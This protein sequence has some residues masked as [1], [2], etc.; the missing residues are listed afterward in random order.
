MAGKTERI[1][2]Y[3]PGPYRALPRPNALYTLADAFGNEL[4]R[5]ENGLAALMF[6]HW[7]DKAD[8]GADEIADL[9]CIAALYG[10]AP[11]DA[12][13]L[14]RPA[15][16]TCPQ[17]ASSETIEAFRL[18]LKRYIRTY[19]D[20]TP[21]VLGVL[22]VVAE[23][24]G[25]ELAD[26][27]ARLDTW[28]TR[29]DDRATVVL[30]ANDDAGSALLGHRA[31]EASGSPARAASFVGTI[32]LRAGFALAPNAS[33]RLGVDGGAF[34]TVDL[35]AFANDV[36]DDRTAAIARALELAI[37]ALSAH[38]ASGRLA[39]ASRSFGTASRLA[40]DDVDGDSA[41]A[42]LG[43]AAHRYRG[44]DATRATLSGRIAL[45]GGIA[46][47]GPGEPRYLRLLIDGTLRG[48]V[49]CAAGIPGLRSASEIAQAIDAQFGFALAS[50]TDDTLTLASQTGG[51]G[52]RIAFERATSDDAREALFGSVSG[53]VFGSDAEAASVTGA[54]DLRGGIDLHERSQLRVA[55]DGKLPVTIDC[56]GVSP[57]ETLPNEIVEAIN[58]ALGAQ[59]ATQDGARVTLR[60]RTIGSTSS[61]AFLAAGATDARAA[62]FGIPER[63]AMGA[64]AS[65]AEIVGTIDLSKDVDIGGTRFLDLAFDGG[66]PIAIDLRA[67]VPYAPATQS[68]LA[69]ASA[70]ARAIDDAVGAAV[71]TLRGNRLVIASRETGAFSAVTLRS[72]ATTVTRRFVTRGLL[73][74]DAAPV[75][76]GTTHALARGRAPSA[77]R[78]SGTVDLRLG[79]D[80]SG[81]RAL[82][83][84]VDGRAPIEIDCASAAGARARAL[85]LDELLVALRAALGDV[86]IVASD[87]GRVVLT[88]KTGG[89]AS[90]I[91]FLAGGS[92]LASLLG[93]S[94]GSA[95]GNDA[96]GV[97]FVATAD[98][99]G[100]VDLTTA[101]H[102][103]LAIDGKIAEID[104]AA[105][106]PDPAHVGLPALVARI[107]LAFGTTV[108]TSDERVLSLRSGTTGAASTIEVLAPAATDA[109]RAL[110]G[111]A[112]GRTYRGRDAE[113]AHVHGSVALAATN[114]LR[115]R[116]FLR[117]A[118]NGGAWHDIDCAGADPAATTPVEIAR[119][120][121]LAI[122]ALA[123]VDGAHLVL[124]APLPGAAS[125]L[126][127]AES[128]AGDARARV[129]GDVPDVTNGEAASSATIAGAVDLLA[130][131][132]LSGGSTLALALDGAPPITIDVAGAAPERTA[133]AEIVGA[134]EA[135]LP[136]VARASADDRLLLA[137][138]RV[139]ALARLELVPVRAIDLVDY[140][141]RATEATTTLA[142]GDRW[143]V[144]NDGA[145]AAS[146]TL[147]ICASQGVDGVQLVRLA[148]GLRLRIKALVGS[149]GRVRVRATERGGL[150][151]ESIAANG[152]TTMLPARALASGPIGVH[153]FVPSTNAVALRAIDAATPRTRALTLDDPENPHVA[154]LRA[155]DD[156]ASDIELRAH[157]VEADLTTIAGTI[158]TDDDGMATIRGRL[159]F[160]G[161][162]Y[163]LHDASET[164][165][166][167]V[168]QTLPHVALD[169]FRDRAIVLTGRLVATIASIPMLVASTASDLFDVEIS[170]R[171]PFGAG[172]GIVERYSAVTIGS[173]E[174]N[175]ASLTRAIATT[176]RLVLAREIPKAR[177]L[178]LPPGKT[179]WLYLDCDDAR[180]DRDR[181][182]RVVFPGLACEE[183]G[184]F[185]ASLFTRA[186]GVAGEP[187]DPRAHFGDARA[188]A[189]STSEIRLAWEQHA[190]GA[191]R[192]DLP[193]DL[194]RAFGARFDVDRFATPRDSAEAYH[195]VI[196]D[197]RG[198]PSDATANVDNLATRINAHSHLVLASIVPRVPIGFD[199]FEMPFHRP[200]RRFLRNG[201]SDAP[202]RLYLTDPGASGFI[203]I[204]ARHNGSFGDAIAVTAR[205]AGPARFDVTVAY[206]G[207]RTENARLTAFAGEIV[208]PERDPLPA[209]VAEILKPR[210][211]GI[212][213]AKA[214]GVR[215]DVS[216]ERTYAAAPDLR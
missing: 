28:W 167:R 216:R 56:R 81:G 111:V 73:A 32:D 83:I 12:E 78:T 41:P 200:R 18:H 166:A 192:V 141:A 40:L 74:T 104:C 34:V 145:V 26:G 132:D 170:S 112:A 14:P 10:L 80:V 131:I 142:H 94:P 116:R 75:L 99:A 128:V 29:A 160:D 156:I 61:V 205:V 163:A 157:A 16:V 105:G 20:G 199:P 52:S 193:A 79:V 91:A 136:G 135:V 70:I 201:R 58:N 182:D 186:R 64:E 123:T 209:L 164:L 48:E 39:I 194:D 168:R 15:P 50:S 27:Y 54:A 151:A 196:V 127:I 45:H 84:A 213:Q 8:L 87:G 23:A 96:L 197:V 159:R 140:P 3:L 82:R 66:P 31:F 17:L 92:A 206:E 68:R 4:Q 117:V 49:D 162:S 1:L 133:L 103:K 125:R 69:S 215:A 195:G 89:S 177:V 188:I 147:E 55:F 106:D 98:L 51:I 198:N 38:V 65:A 30:P 118:V 184:I 158:A 126:D 178:E 47:G 76:L 119:A 203:E 187:E 120:I 179:A 57:G 59:Y 152:A 63:T 173:D 144:R 134:I 214:A 2:G 189:R 46:L 77:A 113:A 88:S 53:L 35:A 169:R 129:F 180:F 176:S 102:L 121:D 19:L 7:V 5:G 114:D 11:R 138:P 172:A 210:P 90:E 93:V 150:E 190:P 154:Q 21:T 110:L 139:G 25:L 143:T 115:I 208:P 165:V 97:T 86:A 191:F 9:A 36:S 108:A 202:A 185:D 109:T 107:N 124:R 13:P 175:A 211:A 181:F 212:V 149:G 6:A 22:R 137:S 174:S 72:R 155:R 42:L 130:P 100:G 171:P 37:P 146:G 161:T 95:H 207:A 62:I 44:C 148:E 24:L 85:T 204:R 153:A 43:I 71:A 67:S 183:R 33:V 122:P 60:S 101:R